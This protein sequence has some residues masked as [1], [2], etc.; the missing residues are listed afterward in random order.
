M[1]LA[2]WRSKTEFYM[3]ETNDVKTLADLIKDV[4]ICMLITNDGRGEL[5]ARPMGTQAVEFDGDLWFFTA[6][7]SEKA[8]EIERTPTVCVSYADTSAHKYISVSGTAELLNDREKM[9]ELWTPMLKLWFDQGVSDPNLRLIRVEVQRAEY[10]DSPGGKLVQLLGF[11]KKA[12]TG[13]AE[14]GENRTLH[15]DAS[16]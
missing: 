12:I 3:T 2:E 9:R 16:R 4:R 1:P 14:I 5:K 6:A 7:D 11:V 15:L 10:W 13:R 8:R